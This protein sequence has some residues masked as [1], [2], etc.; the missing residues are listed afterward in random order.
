MTKIDYKKERYDDIVAI[1]NSS[2]PRKVIV[3]GPGTGKSYLFSELIKNK[4]AEGKTNFLAITFMG[5]LGDE[6]ADDL[7]GLATTVTMHG[8]ARSLVCKHYTSW[9]YYP[10]MHKIIAEDLKAEGIK[11]F[12]IGDKNYTQKT[13]FYEAVGDNDVVHYAVR[14]CKENEN[15]IPTFDLVLIDEYQD[16]NAIESELVDLLAK[17]NEIVIVG[18]DDQSLYGEFRDSSPSFIREKYDSTNKYFESR[19]LRFCSRCTE[20][21]IKYFHAL[22][23]KYNLNN[24]IEADFRKKRIKKEYVCYMP[25]S[26]KDSKIHDSN[27]NPKIHLITQ[28]PVGMIAYK[29][30]DKLKNLIKNQKIKEVLVI[31]EGRSCGPLLKTIA[32]QLKN[33]GFRYVDHKGDGEILP[34]QQNIVS[35]YRF[36][37]KNNESA[38]G[39]R[40]LGNPKDGPEKEKHLKNIKV[41]NLLINGTPSE[42]KKIRYTNISLL[43]DVIED[44]GLNVVTTELKEG[45]SEKIKEGVRRNQDEIIRKD[46]LIREL[47][48]ANLY[49][50]RPL[51]NL[52]I[53]VCNILNSKG[54]GADVVFL[55][56]FDQGKFPSRKEPTE[57]EIYQMLVAI[58]RVKKRMYLINTIGS[59]IST[60]AS[61]LDAAD[62]NIEKIEIRS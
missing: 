12:K 9:S 48:R 40:I 51:C 43:E 3:A 33:Y 24:S 50:P 2:H 29:I 6:L 61:C 7:C 16:F 42:L 20:V 5:K 13:K 22:V 39:W 44:W 38:L 21:I 47:K 17:K 14:I 53:A 15:E 55:I 4:R 23:K 34:I 56:G 62:L 18:D 26:E 25:E 11:S 31:G 45:D 32:Q 57:N 8:F 49:L 46:V 1:K 58:T 41:L 59:K 52:N 28:C 27:A 19:T 37:V 35:A 30:H 10:K 60:F 36:L 54:L